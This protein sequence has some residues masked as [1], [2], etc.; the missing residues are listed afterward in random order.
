[1]LYTCLRALYHPDFFRTK[2]KSD[3][4]VFTHQNAADIHGDHRKLYDP[5]VPPARLY[6][7]GAYM[8]IIMTATDIR[9]VLLR[10]DGY[11]T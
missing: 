7:L 6:Y 9:V 11:H 3:V 5:H 4:L 1:M 2:N 8:R 10:R